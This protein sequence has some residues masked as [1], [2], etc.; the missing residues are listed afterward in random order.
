MRSPNFFNKI[1][2]ADRF[3]T[4]DEVK[5]KKTKVQKVIDSIAPTIGALLIG[6]VIFQ[7][8]TAPKYEKESKELSTGENF[9]NL[10]NREGGTNCN[11]AGKALDKYLRQQSL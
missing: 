5:E 11:T 6:I 9:T 10:C 2:K 4:K 1:D 8:I 7:T 3:E